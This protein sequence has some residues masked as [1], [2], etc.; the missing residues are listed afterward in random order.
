MFPRRVFPVA[1]PLVNT[2]RRAF[3]S[4]QEVRPTGHVG[5]WQA[6]DWQKVIFQRFPAGL[7][8]LV[9]NPVNDG[10]GWELR[11]DVVAEPCRSIPC[12]SNCMSVALGYKIKAA[13]RSAASTCCRPLKRPAQ[14]TM[15][16]ITVRAISVEIALHL[17]PRSFARARRADAPRNRLSHRRRCKPASSTSFTTAAR[18]AC[19]PLPRSTRHRFQDARAR[20]SLSFGGCRALSPLRLI[21]TRGSK[22]A[23]VGL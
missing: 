4:V 12:W 3:S 2:W 13:G 1:K 16:R 10:G 11:I 6:R 9:G 19:P 5:R 23:H 17:V 20:R 8:Q 18:V 7:L 21:A 15:Q 14:I 22:R